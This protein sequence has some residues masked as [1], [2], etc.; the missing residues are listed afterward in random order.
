MKLRPIKT[1]KNYLKHAEGSCMFSMGNTTVLCVASVEDRVPQFIERDGLAQGWVTAEY[2]LLPRAGKQRTP[3]HRGSGGGRSQEISRLIGRSLR[4]VVDMEK[5]G[6]RTI[7][8]D[9]DVL[10]ADGGTR[11]ASI[12]GG[13]IAMYLALQELYKEKLIDS[14][15]V[16]DFLGAVSIGKVSGKI[17]LDLCAE[18]DNNADVDLNLV[19]TGSGSIIEIQG[20]AEGDPFSRKELDSMIT[21][22]GEGIKKIIQLEKKILGVK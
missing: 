12:N 21:T 13:Y 14:W 6:R 1:V 3:R 17:I 8:I 22:A 2:S 10:K 7:I 4:G 15:P 18:E 20:T 11:T 5:L 19:A 16:T 9:C